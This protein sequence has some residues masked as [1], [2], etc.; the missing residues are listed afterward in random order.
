MKSC[1]GEL[2]RKKPDK[3]HT[4]KLAENVYACEDFRYKPEWVSRIP[5]ADY[6]LQVADSLFLNKEFCREVVKQIVEAPL[7]GK[8]YRYSCLNFML[9]KEMVEKITGTPMDVYLDSVFY[10]PMGLRHT[11]FQPLHKFKKEQLVPSV[12]KIC[13]AAA[14]YKGLCRMRRPPLWEAFREMLVCF[15]RPTMW[16]GL[17]RCG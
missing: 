3:N 8:S 4:L 16:P 14:L 2:F 12:E 17:H 11:T 13:C 7:K 6:P 10:S 5:S 9:L 15:L 1:K